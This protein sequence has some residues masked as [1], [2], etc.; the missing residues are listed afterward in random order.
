M[1]VAEA[2][3]AAVGV[4]AENADRVGTFR[5]R[6]RTP[7]P[8]GVAVLAAGRVAGR[9]VGQ[10][11]SAG[12]GFHSVLK[13]EALSEVGQVFEFDEI[14]HSVLPVAVPVVSFVETVAAPE[15][16]GS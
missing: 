15:G 3:V 8:D 6:V 9:G 16:G 11:R 12:R 10:Q 13:V 7:V 1:T 4:S 2:D 14:P 5:K